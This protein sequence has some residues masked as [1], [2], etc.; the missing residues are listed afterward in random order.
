[1]FWKT[2]LLQTLGKD[3]GEKYLLPH[4][5]IPDQFLSL[6]SSD[7]IIATLEDAE[8]M[9]STPSPPKC[10]DELCRP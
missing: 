4:L 6:I 5:A 7:W 8:Q 2:T 3:K 10:P 9:T 1:M